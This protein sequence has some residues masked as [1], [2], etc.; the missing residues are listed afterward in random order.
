MTL[1]IFHTQE[2]P[3]PLSGTTEKQ[4]EFHVVHHSEAQRLVAAAFPIGPY[5]HEIECADTEIR[6][7]TI[8]VHAGK[9]I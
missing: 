2:G 3:A 8:A 4:P 6:L 7:R 5:A 1:H 9:P